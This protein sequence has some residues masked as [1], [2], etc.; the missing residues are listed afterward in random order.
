ME[1]ILGPGRF[2]SDWIAPREGLFVGPQIMAFTQPRLAE[3]IKARRAILLVRLPA[4]LQQ[5]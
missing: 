5:G 1:S 2:G 4:L 3:L